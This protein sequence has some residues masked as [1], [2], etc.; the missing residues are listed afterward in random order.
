MAKIYMQDTYESWTSG[1]NLTIYNIIIW[2]IYIISYN[3]YDINEDIKWNFIFDL[4][5]IYIISGVQVKQSRCWTSG[6]LSFF[7]LGKAIGIMELFLG[8][9][10]KN[11]DFFTFFNVK[12]QFWLAFDWKYVGYTKGVFKSH[13]P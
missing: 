10:V 6:K 13:S 11:D 9:Q 4:T 7:I 12:K 1:L 5:V 3:S 2:N 8:F